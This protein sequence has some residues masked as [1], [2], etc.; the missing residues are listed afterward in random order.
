MPE[1]ESNPPCWSWLPL[2]RGEAAELVARRW[3]GERLNC[4][5]EQLSLRRDEYGRPHLRGAFARWDCNWSH[6]GDGLLVAL[7]QDVRL[8]IDL[9]W[10]RPRPRAM[11]LARRFFTAAEAD[12]LA[13]LPPAH[14]ESGF[15]RLWCAKESVL[16]A[17]GRGLA[18]G[19]DKFE[20]E[21]SDSG[22]HLVNCD[23]ALGDRAQ[24][25]VR[26]LKPQPGYVGAIAWRPERTRN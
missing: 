12:V 24:W 13:S 3:L 15:L 16:K 20:F 23:A 1:S 26:E 19:L 25:S 5:P 14:R 4:P 18:F 10:V 8:G 7:G 21:I 2:P 22:I 11:E 6:S 9:E 17:H